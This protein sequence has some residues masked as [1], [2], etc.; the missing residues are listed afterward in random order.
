[1]QAVYLEF[2]MNT[3][4]F[5]RSQLDFPALANDNLVIRLV[6]SALGD[7]LDLVHNI[8]ALED[9]AKDDMLPIK[10]SGNGGSDEKLLGSVS[11]LHN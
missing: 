7:V 3:F 2:H 4:S 9:F 6:A 1:M 5:S 8:I 11:T 10:P